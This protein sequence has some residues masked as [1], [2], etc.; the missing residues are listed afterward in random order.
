MTQLPSRKPIADRLFVDETAVV[1]SLAAEAALAPD[2]QRQGCRTRPPARR[3][4]ARRPPP[5]GRHRRLHAVIFAV[6][7][8]GVVLMCLAE[9]LLRIPDA[10]TADKLIADKIGGKDWE[11]HLGQSGSLFVNA[12]AWGLMLTGVSSTSGARPPATSAA[13]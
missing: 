7:E 12:S 11:G 9:A 6:S 4:G 8:E 3:G 5:A 10:G 2:E 13:M 1:R